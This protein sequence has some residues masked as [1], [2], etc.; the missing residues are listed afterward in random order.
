[1]LYR[2]M[3]RQDLPCPAKLQSLAVQVPWLCMSIQAWE[4]QSPAPFESTSRAGQPLRTAILSTTASASARPTAQPSK[5][6][7]M[8]PAPRTVLGGWISVLRPPRPCLWA[9]LCYVQQLYVARNKWAQAGQG[10]LPPETGIPLGCTL[11]G[12][13][14]RGGGSPDVEI[15]GV[16]GCDLASL[17]GDLD[18]Q[19]SCQ[20]AGTLIR[21][22]KV[23]ARW[24]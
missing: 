10:S 19:G 20:L 24:P 21:A 16:W 22:S 5:G 17:P 2:R 3:Q 7:D 13:H 9:G 1:M 11:W 23:R 8:P 4:R 6:L 14:W 15:G 12:R 18:I